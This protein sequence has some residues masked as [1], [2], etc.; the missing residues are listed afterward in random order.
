[1]REPTEKGE[2]DIGQP[3]TDLAASHFMGGRLPLQEELFIFCGLMLLTCLFLPWQGGGMGTTPW[4]I[5]SGGGSNI[6]GTC[7]L[8]FL[9]LVG[10]TLWSVQHPTFR[11]WFGI[12]TALALNVAVAVF[13][14][15]QTEAYGA[16]YARLFAFGLLILSANPAILVAGDFAMR[17]LNSRNAEVFTHWGTVLPEMHFSAQEFYAKLEKAIHL[18]QWP[19]VEFLRVLY[20]EAGLLSHR[21]E[22]LRIIRQRQIFDVSAG[23]FGKDF[24]FTLREAEIRPQVTLATLIILLLAHTI[25][26]LMSVNSVGL[27]ATVINFGIVLTIGAFLLFNVLRMGMTRLDGILMRTPVIGP[28]YETWFRSSSTYFQHDT[29][30]VFLKLMDDL[31]KEHVDEETSAKG[32]K[33]LSCFEHQP[34]LDGIYKISPRTPK[35]KD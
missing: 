6:A 28:V 11:P 4:D 3:A 22:Y 8:L 20:S 27:I 25:L 17:R 2:Q 35:P 31:V 34:I 9:P 18:R 29:R 15:G 7:F 10:L 13:N 33:H 1:M 24:F 19:G 14:A 32:V 21:R 12:S 26:F 23:T 30:M 5:A 16:G